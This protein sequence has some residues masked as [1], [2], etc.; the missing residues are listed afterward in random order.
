MRNKFL[1][2]VQKEDLIHPGEKVLLGV[3][4]GIDS[5]VMA[6]LFWQAGIKHGIAHCN[7][8]LRG[9]E[10]EED[11]KFVQ[12]YAQMRELPFFQKRFKTQEH[13]SNHNT[14]IQMSARQLRFSWFESIAREHSYDLIATAHH[15]DDQLETFF[16]NLMRS[17]GIA[18]F[19]GILPRQNKIIHPLLFACREEIRDYSIQYNIHFREDSSNQTTKYARNKIRHDIIPLFEELH[20]NFRE[21]LHANIRRIRETEKVYRRAVT[22]A[23]H[24][25]TTKIDGY[26][27]VII[28]R[29][30]DTDS[31]TLYLFEYLAEFQFKYST[32]E[33]IIK[34]IEGESGKVFNSPA[35]QL[36][37]ER[38]HLILQKRNS[39][40]DIGEFLITKDQ[41]PGTT[42]RPIKLEMQWTQRDKKFSIR[43]DPSIAQIDAD[44]LSWPL[45]ITRW[46]QGDYF[47]PLGMTRAK[48][49]SDFF[50]DEKVPVY[51]K[52]KVP[53]LRSGDQVVWI[54]GMR[55]DNRFKIDKNTKNI[56]EIHFK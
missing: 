41:I 3:S 33:D 2:Y 17:T 9:K 30:M 46:Q 4:G 39:G 28:N 12:E 11:E 26:P 52:Q 40:E 54:V 13:A 24:F 55:L 15:K 42:N 35:Y 34:S 49:I 19:H 47:F 5:M 21:I 51:R 18:G 14:S 56:L 16:L 44:K 31:P 10:A 6:E 32:A 20:P 48:K 43:P 50:I 25:I 1:K 27:A 38:E 29:L 53:L 7:F 45:R 22:N 8:N 23:I 37:K 36:I